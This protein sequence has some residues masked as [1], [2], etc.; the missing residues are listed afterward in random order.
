MLKGQLDLDKCKTKGLEGDGLPATGKAGRIFTFEVRKPRL[1]AILTQVSEFHF[2]RRSS[3]PM[4]ARPQCTSSKLC[5]PTTSPGGTQR[6][7]PP[8]LPRRAT[9]LTS[10]VRRRR[11][12]GRPQDLASSAVGAEPEPAP[13]DEDDEED[14]L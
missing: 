6:A 13:V 7:P 5:Q 14:K 1:L 11:L 4:L 3:I 9:E 2:A 10:R 12:L 8:P